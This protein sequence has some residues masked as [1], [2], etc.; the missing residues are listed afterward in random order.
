[1]VLYSSTGRWAGLDSNHN[2]YHG[3]GDR[4]MN[5]ICCGHIWRAVNISPPVLNINYR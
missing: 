1:M 2:N 5:T 4:S 3:A